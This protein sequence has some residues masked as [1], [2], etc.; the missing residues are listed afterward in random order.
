MNFFLLKVL[1]KF[2]LDVLLIKFYQC[3]IFCESEDIHGIHAYSSLYS[4]YTEF[5]VQYFYF[6][7]TQG[8]LKKDGEDS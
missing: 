3:M 6:P 4:F 1:I 7:I 2:E 5:N 8:G